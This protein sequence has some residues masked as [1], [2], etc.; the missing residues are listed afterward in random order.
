MSTIRTQSISKSLTISLVAAIVVIS[1]A[2]ST[3]N[4]Y[5]ISERE[6]AWLRGKAD[7]SIRSIARTLEVPLWNIDRRSIHA[8]C[9][10]YSQSE[11]IEAVKLSDPSGEIL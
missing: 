5:L 3:L 4:Y 9:T 10:Y 2:F 11:W 6:K 7:E 8:I 1:L